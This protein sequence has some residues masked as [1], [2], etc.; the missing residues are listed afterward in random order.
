M[1]P[2]DGRSYGRFQAAATSNA[3]KPPTHPFPGRVASF[4]PR[5]QDR[6]HVIET[7]TVAVPVPVKKRAKAT[8][9]AKEYPPHEHFG[10]P[11]NVCRVCGAKY[12]YTPKPYDHAGSN[13]K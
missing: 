5:K 4:Q 12:T 10:S 9:V 8:P 2:L 11:L 3:K 6:D 7:E 13:I 1:P